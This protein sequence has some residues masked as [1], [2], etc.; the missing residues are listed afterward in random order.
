MGIYVCALAWMIEL[1][2]YKYNY[3]AGTVAFHI[4]LFNDIV[5]INEPL[6][7]YKIQID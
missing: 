1:S 3:I 4:C 5:L 7:F 2:I 6:V